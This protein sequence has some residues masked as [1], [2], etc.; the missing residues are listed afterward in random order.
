MSTRYPGVGGETL[1]FV[2][3]FSGG[4]GG[5]KVL[6]S[7]RSQVSHL[8]NTGTAVADPDARKWHSSAWDSP[9]LGKTGDCLN[10]PTRS[11]L[12]LKI[13]DRPQA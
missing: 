12:N 13:S 11:T 5:G 7:E 10:K 1:R 3:F 6:M 2:F 8:H 9:A 4:R